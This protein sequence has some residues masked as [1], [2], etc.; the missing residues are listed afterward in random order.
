MDKALKEERIAIALVPKR[1]V[2]IPE[3]T[4]KPTPIDIYA[5]SG[6]VFGLNLKQQENEFF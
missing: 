5:I 2:L 1:V 3:L 6:A 4:P